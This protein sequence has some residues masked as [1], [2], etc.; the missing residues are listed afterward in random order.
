MPLEGSQGPRINSFSILPPFNHTTHP[1]GT[2]YLV[3]TQVDGTSSL[4]LPEHA[5]WQCFSATDPD[6]MCSFYICLNAGISCICFS[7]VYSGYEVS[8]R[9][10]SQKKVHSEIEVAWQMQRPYFPPLFSSVSMVTAENLLIYL[11]VL[12]KA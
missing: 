3:C 1:P 11:F 5:D 12:Y 6:R 2:T 8:N 9:T 7:H 4:F 10:S